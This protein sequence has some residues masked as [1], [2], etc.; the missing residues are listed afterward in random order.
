M[1]LAILLRMGPGGG[2][3]IYIKKTPK[4]NQKN[5]R[6]AH[7]A[8]R[9]IERDYTHANGYQNGMRDTSVKQRVV[10]LHPKARTVLGGPRRI[11]VSLSYVDIMILDGSSIRTSHQVTSQS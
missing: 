4:K 1:Y 11:C 6:I 10:L 2:G 5:N 7:A 8:L 9:R 3:N